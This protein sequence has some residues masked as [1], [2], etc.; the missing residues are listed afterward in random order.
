MEDSFLETMFIFT[1]WFLII[2]TLKV[3]YRRTKIFLFFYF[4]KMY[5]YLFVTI[6]IIIM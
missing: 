2:M 5:K 6:I 1:D 4:E 3:G